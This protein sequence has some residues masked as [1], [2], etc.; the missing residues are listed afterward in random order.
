[1]SASTAAIC[2]NLKGNVC[3]TDSWHTTHTVC[4]TDSWHTTHT[5]CRTDS[6]HT[7]HTV[8]RTDSWHTPHVLS[9]GQL[10]HATPSLERTV[11]TRPT[12]CQTE[13]WH[14]PHRLSDGQLTHVPHCLSLAISSP[15]TSRSP[16]NTAMHWPKTTAFPLQILSQPASLS[17]S[18]VC[19]ILC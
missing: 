10:T 13:S 6:W 2:N 5:V 12:V 1:M 18:A 8:C 7:P 19:D 4:R 9:D 17:L 3:R 14:T 11:D 15:F 16:P